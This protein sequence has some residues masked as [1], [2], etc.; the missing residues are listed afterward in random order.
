MTDEIG[1]DVTIKVEF[2]AGVVEGEG[3][4]E[5]TAWISAKIAEFCY[6]KHTSENQTATAGQG[7]SNG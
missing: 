2:S 5:I 6:Q 3:A 4:V 1:V 7:G